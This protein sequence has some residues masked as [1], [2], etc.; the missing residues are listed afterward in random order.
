MNGKKRIV[1]LGG[2]Y[3]GVAAAKTLL[4]KFKKDRN[5]EITL[6]DRNRFQTLMTELHEIAG[7]RVEQDAV[8]VSF[9]KIFGGRRITVIQDNIET[10]D[11]EGRKLIGAAGAYEYDYLVL[12]V[13]GGTGGFR[14]AWNKE[15]RVYPVV[16]ERRAPAADPYRGDVL[17]S[18]DGAGSGKT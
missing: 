13:G 15:A 8:Q 17:Q 4:G 18:L 3:A 6:I 1:I 9:A 2:G 10:I 16:A 7:G 11:F 14:H 5:I 12:G